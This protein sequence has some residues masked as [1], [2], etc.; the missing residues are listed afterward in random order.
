VDKFNILENEYMDGQ[1]TE[2]GVTDYRNEKTK[3]DKTWVVFVD[4]HS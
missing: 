1:F 4:M 3:G 2:S